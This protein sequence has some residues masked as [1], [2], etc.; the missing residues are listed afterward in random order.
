MTKRTQTP[1]DVRWFGRPLSDSS[2]MRWTA[3]EI[4]AVFPVCSVQLGA[5]RCLAHAVPFSMASDLDTGSP[6]VEIEMENTGY[7]EVRL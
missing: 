1:C 7:E 2:D 5:S 6:F 4:V 3:A